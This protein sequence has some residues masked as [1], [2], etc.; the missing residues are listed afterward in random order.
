MKKYFKI[1]EVIGHQVLIHLCRDIDGEDYVEIKT[2]IEHSGDTYIRVEEIRNKSEQ[3]LRQIVA[4]YS[5][6]SAQVFI[7]SSEYYH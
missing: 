1:I 4:D 3:V 2:F 6:T 5:E 7:E